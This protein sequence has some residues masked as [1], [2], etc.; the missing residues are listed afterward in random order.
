MLFTLKV[1]V[2]GGEPREFGGS[3]PLFPFLPCHWKDQDGFHLETHPD[4]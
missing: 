4:S 1:N 2:G 3:F